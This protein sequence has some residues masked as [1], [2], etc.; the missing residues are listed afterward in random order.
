MD[1]VRFGGGLAGFVEAFARVVPAANIHHGYA[2]LIVFVSS[3]RVLLLA[4][5]HALLGDFDVHARTIGEFFTG[6]FEDFL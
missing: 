5:L 2:T 4:G 1:I 6:A 3:A